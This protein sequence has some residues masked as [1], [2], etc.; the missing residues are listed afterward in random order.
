MFAETAE[1]MAV[2]PMVAHPAGILAMLLAVLAGIFWLTQHPVAGRIFKIIPSLVFCYFVPTLLVVMVMLK[3]EYLLQI[4]LTALNYM[5]DR[6]TRWNQRISE[7]INQR[8]EEFNA[9]AIIFFTRGDNAA[10]LNRVMLYVKENETTNRLLLVHIYTEKDDIPASLKRDIKYLDK[11]YPEI[12]MQLVLRKGE[13]GP[14][15]VDRLSRELNVP[16]N[17]M[18]I[19]HPGQDYPHNIADLGG[20]RLII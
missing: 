7:G 16:K 8:I 14:E 3:R 15:M 12:K 18:F 19:G 11:I 9:Q 2:G 6:V 5:A 13:F 4:V 10:N 20:V 17:Y 1:N